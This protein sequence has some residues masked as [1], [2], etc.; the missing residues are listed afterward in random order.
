MEGGRLQH[1]FR[2][3][4]NQKK[5]AELR[6]KQSQILA[7]SSGVVTSKLVTEGKFVRKGEKVVLFPILLDRPAK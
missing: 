7:P 1:N 4:L 2:T 5:L 6:V 3:S